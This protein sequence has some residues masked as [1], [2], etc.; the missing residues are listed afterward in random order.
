MLFLTF[1]KKNIPETTIKRE[2]KINCLPSPQRFLYR[3]K[4]LRDENTDE[5]HTGWKRGIIDNDELTGAQLYAHYKS[6]CQEEHER[7]LSQTKF[8]RYIGTMIT[9]ARMK[10]GFKFQ[11]NNI[12]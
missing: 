11:L 2:I 4:E 1:S 12:K 9:K 10:N 3:V 7:E 5:E 6:Y 8:G